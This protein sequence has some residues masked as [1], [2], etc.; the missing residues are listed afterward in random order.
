M[1]FLSAK[2]CEGDYFKRHAIVY[3]S[4]LLVMMQLELFTSAVLQKSFSNLR[5]LSIAEICSC[6]SK[7]LTK[8]LF[9]FCTRKTKSPVSF[10]SVTEKDHGSPHFI[11]S[12]LSHRVPECG[13]DSMKDNL[14][15]T[16]TVDNIQGTWLWAVSVSLRQHM[17]PEP[18][19]RRGYKSVT[20]AYCEQLFLVI[21]TYST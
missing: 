18:G 4:L 6:E 17:I 21:W 16:I 3:D 10:N 15:Q 9:F 5:T 1:F 14:C 11:A 7:E 13:P 8:W 12:Y 2:E 19:L 20:K